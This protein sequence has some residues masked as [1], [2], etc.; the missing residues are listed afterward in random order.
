[1]NPRPL[2][3]IIPVLLA[4][5]FFFGCGRPSGE[6][7]Y[8]DAMGLWKQGDRVRAR[9]LLEK[10]IRRRAGSLENAVALNR[11]GLLLWEMGSPGEAADAFSRSLRVNADQY[12][13]LC[14]LGVALAESGDAS[15]AERILR[16]AALLQP[17]SLRPL[18]R[19]GIA[20]VR[21]EQ[22]ADGARN[23][24]RALERD[25]DNPQIQTALALAELNLGGAEAALRRLQ[26]VSR[27]H[28]DYAPA[29]FNRASIHLHQQK[30]PTEARR[31]FELYLSRSSGTDAFAERAREHLQKLQPKT[32]PTT[33]PTTASE[34]NRAKAESQ[35]RTALQLHRRQRL[36]E[37]EQAYRKAL[38]LDSSHEQACYNLGLIYY[39]RGD[40]AEAADAFERAVELNPA[41]TAARYNL[42]LTAHRTGNDARARQELERL[43]EQQP[44]YQPARDLRARLSR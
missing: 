44:D 40:H 17:G 36:E 26:S 22:W 16:E 5:A 29:L 34:P 38:E 37:A 13:V 3:W 6:K 8:H 41:F 23:L 35:F 1:M 10:S 19:A 20:Y 14:N 18:A 27:E 42:A 2:Q 25:P 28:P 24:S 39:N 30:N 7:L 43:L 33:R 15:G 9:T 11:L 32:S 31:L 4:G 21:T 12:D